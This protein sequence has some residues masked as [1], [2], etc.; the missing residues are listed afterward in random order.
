MARRLGTTQSRISKLLA[1][2]TQ[3]SIFDLIGISQEM[4]VSLD[5]VIYGQ[6][7]A[8][9]TNELKEM[10]LAKPAEFVRSLTKEE[11]KIILMEIANSF[12]DPDNNSSE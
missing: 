5:Q 12:T 10:V 1:G 9:D 8:A 4:G 6:L 3:F 7:N 11:K 2:E